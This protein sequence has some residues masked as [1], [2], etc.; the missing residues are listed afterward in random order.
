MQLF[1]VST[2][3]KIYNCGAI[4]V[5]ILHYV[6]SNKLYFSHNSGTNQ[7]GNGDK[8]SCIRQSRVTNGNQHVQLPGREAST[9]N[10][11]HTEHSTTRTLPAHKARVHYTMQGQ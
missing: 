4:R 10:L 5:T 3:S 6:E 1:R 9:I 8:K 7:I 11:K 2:K